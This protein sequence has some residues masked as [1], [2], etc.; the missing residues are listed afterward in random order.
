MSIPPE[1]A[2]IIPVVLPFIMGLLVGA[3]LK[4]ALKILILVVA[5]IVVLIFTGILSV[6]LGDVFSALPKLYDVGIG[7]LNILPYSSVA[8]IVG[9]AVGFL[10]TQ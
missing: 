3:I 10:F 2:W 7:W 8:F 6:T 4:K 9:L 5:L 1:I